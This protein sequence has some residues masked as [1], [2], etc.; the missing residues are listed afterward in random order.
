MSRADRRRAKR[1]G[2]QLTTP[3][4]LIKPRPE[5][6][7]VNALLAFP[8]WRDIWAPLVKIML[9]IVQRSF[10]TGP[11]YEL[12]IPYGDSLITRSRNRIA[13]DFLIE[14]PNVDVVVMIDSDITFPLKALDDLVSLAREK[15]GVAGG[16][17]A[18]RGK[19][20]WM[21]V[22]TLPDQPIDIGPDCAP[23]EVRYV[24]GAF[25]AIH[26]S[27][28][29]KLR[30]G[31]ENVAFETPR[32][33]FFDPMAQQYKDRGLEDLSEDFAFCQRARDAGFSVWALTNHQIEH[34]GF[35]AY[36]ISLTKAYV[37][38]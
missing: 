37:S 14:Q 20:T 11:V 24:G 29:E 33:G 21:N 31:M 25:M 1:E 27:V 5:L 3:A 32:W 18:I 36:K 35:Y 28:L 8:T 2:R 7:P 15:R 4:P 22:R 9:L 38:D 19:K 6:P 26:R 34:H 13:S 23:Q 10:V 30:E 16:C 17:I 12:F